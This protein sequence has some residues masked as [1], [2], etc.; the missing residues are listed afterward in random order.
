MPAPPLCV[1]VQTVERSLLIIGPR[2]PTI[3]GI[4][5]LFGGASYWIDTA[6]PREQL[7]ITSGAGRRR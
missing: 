6:R 4:D 2:Q 3:G 5:L 7:G 1:E